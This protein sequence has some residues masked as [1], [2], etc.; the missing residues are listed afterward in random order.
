MLTSSS[1]VLPQ[2]GAGVQQGEG[3]GQQL[4][5]P[6][7]RGARD[8]QVVLQ[9]WAP[10]RSLQQQDLHRAAWGTHTGS[11]GSHRKV[12]TR[13]ELWVQHPQNGPFPSGLDWMVPVGPF[14]LT[15]SHGLW[16]GGFQAWSQFLKS[17]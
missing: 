8:G 5:V 3:V 11:A 6:C 1:P 10:L 2:A 9:A 14:Q 13:A 15:I 17:S 12:L 7:G 16:P 4:L